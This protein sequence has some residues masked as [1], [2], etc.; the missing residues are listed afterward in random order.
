MKLIF[1]MSSEYK[2][3]NNGRTS[4]VEERFLSIISS[5]EAGN[6]TQKRSS[7]GDVRP[8]FQGLE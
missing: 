1:A 2:P 6:Y 3:W 8:L 7:T 5:Y 4:P